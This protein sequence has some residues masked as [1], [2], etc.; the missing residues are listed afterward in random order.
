MPRINV[1]P[2]AAEIHWKYRLESIQSTRLGKIL[3]QPNVD[4]DAALAGIQN[5]GLADVRFIPA[6]EKI[7]IYYKSLNESGAGPPIDI[8]RTAEEFLL[9]ADITKDS[10]IFDMRGDSAIAL[11][12]NDIIKIDD[13]LLVVETIGVPAKSSLYIDMVAFWKLDEAGNALVRRNIHDAYHLSNFSQNLVGSASGPETGKNAAS[14]VG[15]QALVVDGGTGHNFRLN[16]AAGFTV[17]GWVYLS[18]KTQD[19]YIVSRWGS[20]A[21]GRQI[22]RLIFDSSSDEFRFS[23]VNQVGNITTVSN[24]TVNNQ[25]FANNWYFVCGWFD[26]E[27]DN[28]NLY[29]QRAGSANSEIRSVAAPDSF[30]TASSIICIGSR[31]YESSK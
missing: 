23:V 7:D 9:D 8:V 29:V 1:R 21:S 14:F 13:E 2:T 28:I 31:L 27:A 17:S 15:N 25:V 26:P 4:S 11:R 10:T 22:F 18:D 6:T 20:S 12:A 30:R 16:A 19:R 3:N 24:D 5:E